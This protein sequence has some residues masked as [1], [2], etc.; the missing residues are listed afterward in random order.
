VLHGFLEL[1]PHLAVKLMRAL[2]IKGSALW[3]FPI[4]K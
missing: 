2:R 4:W 1:F 3:A